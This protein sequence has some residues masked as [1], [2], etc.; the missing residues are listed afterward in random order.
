MTPE[1]KN[2]HEHVW[3]HYLGVHYNRLEPRKQRVYI[4]IG[5]CDCGAVRTWFA[6]NG[7]IDHMENIYDPR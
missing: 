1:D 2:K 6:Y 3:V 4:G 7:L 5:S